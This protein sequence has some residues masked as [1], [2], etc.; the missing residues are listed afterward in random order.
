MTVTLQPGNILVMS[1]G[2]ITLQYNLN[3]GTADCFWQNTRRITAFYAGVGLNSGY[4]KG[5]AFSNRTYTITST[6]EVVVSSVAGGLPDMAQHFVLDQTDSFLTRVDMSGASVSANWM[7][8]VVVDTTGGVDLGSYTDDRALFVPF[9]NDHFIRYNAMPL[10]SSGTSYEVGA[11]YDNSSRIGLVVGSITHDTWKSGVYW[12][13][14]NNKL[15]KMNVFGG[16]VSPS[17]TWDVLPHG[18]VS[19]SAVAS[20]TMFVGFGADW[21]RTLEAFA[22]ANARLTPM[23]PWT[24]GVPFGWNSWGYYQSHINYSLAIGVSDSIHTNLQPFNFNN[25]GIVYV[26]LDSYWDNMTDTQLAAFASHCHANGQRAGIYWSPF[27]WWGSSVNASN[28]WVEGTANAFHYSDVLLRTPSGNYETNDGA[29]AMDPTHPGTQER[30]TYYADRFLNAGFDYIKIDFLSHGA[31]EGVH[32]NSAVTTGIQAY[33][34]GMR[35]LLT[36]LNGHMFISESIAPLFPYQ[37]A[38]ARRIACDAQSSRISDTAYTMNS[39]TYGWWMGGRLYAYNDPDVMVFGNGA[40]LSEN[41]SRVICGAI[42][43]LFLDGDS[44]SNSASIGAAQLSLTNAALDALAR[45]AHSFSPVEGNT[46]ANPAN[47]FVWQDGSGW[48][49]AVF[50]FNTYPTNQA[51]SLARAGITGNVSPLDL[52]SGVVLP[53]TNSFLPVSLNGA[54]AKIFRLRTQPRLLHSRSDGQQF[55]FDLQ[56]DPDTPYAIQETSD[57][58][59]WSTLGFLTNVTGLASF[60]DAVPAGVAARAYRARLVP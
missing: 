3:A 10:N 4:V 16:A 11:F 6:N 51:I 48:Y 32:Y 12:S 22:D 35:Y 14:S 21:R 38:H 41:Q 40:S 46:G 31:L 24:N 44:L 54:Q 26:N 17:V 25:T 34:Q 58:A 30:I 56:G 2:N 59:A 49:L 20:P 43:G 42:T 5:L 37:Y 9:D 1:N 50:N 18:F 23:L 7:G 13:G 57:L 47:Q 39:I 45:A 15:D 28:S 36:R 29:L 53:L 8:P 19:G 52:W 33:N 27:V 55:I 60:T